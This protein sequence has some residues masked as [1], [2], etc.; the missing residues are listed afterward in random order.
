M[1]NAVN[2]INGEIPKDKLQEV[3]DRVGKDDAERID[4]QEFTIA[5]YNLLVDAKKGQM[6]KTVIDEI[7]DAVESNKPN[8][9]NPENPL[10]S[11]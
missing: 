10:N 5:I 9:N 7:I 6:F 2:G 8:L 1:L 3:F 4:L 11:R